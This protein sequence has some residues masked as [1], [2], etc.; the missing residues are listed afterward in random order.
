[1]FAQ[2]PHL[3]NEQDYERV[4]NSLKHSDLQP[5]AQS[6]SSP[7]AD[8][9]SSR[10]CR[11][12]AKSGS[13]DVTCVFVSGTSRCG[14]VRPGWMEVL[15]AATCPRN[16]PAYAIVPS[17]RAH[18]R[19]R[20]TPGPP[21]PPPLPCPRPAQAPRTTPY[22]GRVD[23]RGRLRGPVRSQRVHRDRPMGR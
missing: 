2:S 12:P 10:I 19:T 7:N 11:G 21:T 3:M 17:Q 20:L 9:S 1:M 23:R 16:T 14:R 5:S 8:V 15:H 18:R 6:L 13:R 22:A 4:V